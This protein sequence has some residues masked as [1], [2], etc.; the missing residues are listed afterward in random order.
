MINTQQV[1]MVTVTPALAAEWLK[2]NTTNRPLRKI[3]VDTYARELEQGHWR[4]TGDSIKFDADCKLI[5][6]QHRLAACVKSGVAFQVLVVRGLDSAAFDVLDRN[7]PRSASDVFAQHQIKEQNRVTAAARLVIGYERG[8]LHNHNSLAPFTTTSC[9]LEE[10]LPHQDVYYLAARVAG[11]ARFVGFN[12]SAFTAFLVL[13]SR[14]FDQECISEFA[15]ATISGAGLEEGD[16]RIALINVMRGPHRPKGNTETL[17]SL[18]RA[19]NAWRRNESRKL[20]KGWVRGTP[21][22]MFDDAT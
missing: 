19:W 22:P 1:E 10:V 8:L 14:R 13:A 18:I 9:M 21:F 17:A 11:R 5:D 3:R 15:E 4:F 6:G 16:A 12:P 2:C 20:I 7:L